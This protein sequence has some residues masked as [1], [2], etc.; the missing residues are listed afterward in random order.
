MVGHLDAAWERQLRKVGL[1]ERAASLEPARALLA[2]QT[3]DLVL[4]QGPPARIEELLKVAP[5]LIHVHED[6]EQSLLRSVLDN[7]PHMVFVKD[8]QDLRFVR[9]NKAGA[10][11]VGISQEEMIGKTDFDFF[12]EDEAAVFQ[13][14]DREVLAG[15][16]V[17]DIP[18][19]TLNTRHG[20]RILHTKKIP[21]CNDEGEPVY[22]LG[23]S[24]D[25][26][27]LKEIK[28]QAASRLE[29]AREAER[30]HIAREL[31][32]EL[33]QL[34]TALKLDLGRLQGQLNTELRRQTDSM[35]ELLDLTIKT[36]RRLATELRPQ[37]LD[38]LGLKAGLEWLLKQSCARKGLTYE[39]TWGLAEEQVTD[40]ARSTLF[41]ICQE[42]LNNVVR[43]S[44]ARH[45]LVELRRDRRRLTLQVTDD[46]VGFQPNGSPRSGLGLLGMEERIGLLGGT[47][48]LESRQGGGTRVHIQAPLSRCLRA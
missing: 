20:V 6:S 48:H 26:T 5:H 47:M 31:H 3:F 9:W 37:I 44:E 10:Q 46:G 29:A 42:A 19:E 14:K 8:A 22:L 17:H 30:R 16:G 32:D 15:Q 21:I 1:V 43:H 25:I 18:E 12:P 24:E 41:R 33:G 40:D 35:S 27:E 28:A 4:A 38:D 39:L 45:V 23:I 34:L 2:T 7:L 11:L 36:V 13:R